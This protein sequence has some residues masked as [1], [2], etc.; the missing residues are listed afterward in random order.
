[1]IDDIEDVNEEDTKNKK[2]KPSGEEDAT[3]RKR[4][5]VKKTSFPKK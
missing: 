2:A 5:T 3:K 1:M 4:T